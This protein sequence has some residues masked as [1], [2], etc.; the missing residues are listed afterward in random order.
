MIV[1]YGDKVGI[2]RTLDEA[3]ADVLG[4]D[5]GTT[6]PPETGRAATGGRQPG[7]TAATTRPGPSTQQ[8]RQKLTQAQAAFDRCR[9]GAGRPATRSPGPRRSSG[10]KRLVTQAVALANRRDQAAAPPASGG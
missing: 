5:P 8:I 3:L 4:V 9:R 6:T 10:R 1:S 7:T 2:G